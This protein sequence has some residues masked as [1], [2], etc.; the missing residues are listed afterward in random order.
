MADREQHMT[1][2][3]LLH[4]AQ[5]S[6]AHPLGDRSETGAETSRSVWRWR[7]MLPACQMVDEVYCSHSSVWLLKRVRSRDGSRI[8]RFRVD[9]K[10]ISACLSNHLK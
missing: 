8:T 2:D 5:L 4:V 6:T 7:G 10:A 9:L 1:A 3:W